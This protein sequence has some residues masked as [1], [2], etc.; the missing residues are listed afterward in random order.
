VVETTC[1]SRAGFTL[2]ELLVSIGIMVLLAGLLYT[3]SG[4]ARGRAY[5]T[6]CMNNLHQFGKAIQMYR[7]DY[8]GGDP[9]GA[10]TYSQL[11]LPVRPQLLVPYLGANLGAFRCPVLTFGPDPPD[12]EV[13]RREQSRPD[14]FWYL[15]Q[16][17]PDAYPFTPISGTF[18][19]WVGRKG[20]D[21][22]LVVDKSHSELMWGKTKNVRFIVLRLD[23]RVQNYILPQFH[24]TWDL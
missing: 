14:Y 6:H 8:G 17:R 3:A 13:I 20:N 5:Q 23:G 12:P 10:L 19:Y 11:G 16:P 21:L 4:P 1:R 9:P 24:N 18:S 2:V 7:Q 22:P 15:W